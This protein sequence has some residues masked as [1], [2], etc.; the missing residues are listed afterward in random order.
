M[1]SELDAA[2]FAGGIGVRLDA[3]PRAGGGPLLDL[4]EGALRIEIDA[5]GA[6][7]VSVRTDQGVQRLAAGPL[8]VGTWHSI[9][10]EVAAGRLRLCVDRATPLELAL[11]ADLDLPIGTLPLR[12]GEGFSGNLDNVALFAADSPALVTFHD[13]STAAVVELDASGRARLGLYSTA[14]LNAQEAGAALPDHSVALIGPDGRHFVNLLSRTYYTEL[15]GTVATALYEGAEVPP[16]D[17]AGLASR[18]SLVWLA[19]AGNLLVPPAQAGWIDLSFDGFLDAL[20][21]A[22]SWAL[23]I[24]E[25][26]AIW[27]QLQYLASD[28]GKFDAVTLA[29]NV[30]GVCTYFPVARPLQPVVKPL[31]RFY[32]LVGNKPYT[33]AVASVLGEIFEQVYK[34]GNLDRLKSLVPYLLI[35]AEMLNEP[36]AMDLMV[37]AV[38]SSDDLWTWIAFFNLPAEG[39]DGTGESPEVALAPTGRSPAGGALAQAAREFGDFLIPPASAGV[40]YP[41][42]AGREL[43][44]RILAIFEKHK[45]LAPADLTQGLKMAVPALKATQTAVRRAVASK[46][47]LQLT[48]AYGKRGVAN[49]GNFLRG[50]SNSRIHP[51]LV[52]GILAYLEDRMLPDGRLDDDRIRDKVR[53]IYAK[54]MVDVSSGKLD[55]ESP[56]IDEA[57]LPEGIAGNVST[58]TVLNPGAQGAFFHLA[59]IAYYTAAG[60]TVKDV[61]GSRKVYFYRDPSE[62]RAHRPG[63]STALR[64]QRFVDVVLGDRGSAV[65]PER[66]MELKSLKRRSSGEVFLVGDGFRPLNHNPVSGYRKSTYHAQ[67]V[68][69]WAALKKSASATHVRTPLTVIGLGGADEP[70]DVTDFRW[71]LHKFQVKKAGRVVEQSPELGAIGQ[72]GSVR[73]LQTEI[74]NADGKLTAGRIA[75]S[76][77]VKGTSYL[78]PTRGQLAERIE[79]ASMKNLCYETLK[80]SLS[81]KLRTELGKLADDEF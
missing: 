62:K 68:R 6:L 49:W 76:L 40:K 60:E 32:R 38:N 14:S 52:L 26:Q 7:A 10:A 44:G 30:V 15:A 55:E 48:A 28:P 71:W 77:N 45:G 1:Q 47:F 65:S 64:Y 5:A 51:L 41:R 8:A 31:Q 61:E 19:A 11:A 75:L 67:F 4:A 74:P 39:W 35:V 81:D 36:G 66:W 21:E 2:T 20:E 29:I 58:A 46:E 50:K 63:L 59:M 22:V 57:D 42:F 33:K 18:R 78:G 53:L 34:R 56:A 80:S 72:T 17:P 73:D 9:A 37:A 3:L 54:A 27:Q 69:D 43:A 25:V 16:L 23:P 70:I 79:L 12:L 24:H 13:G